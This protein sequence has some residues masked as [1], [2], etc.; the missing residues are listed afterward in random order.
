MAYNSCEHESIGCSPYKILHGENIVLPVDIL[1]D[2][3]YASDTYE[4]QEHV[5]GFVPKLQS[6]LKRIHAY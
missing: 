4:N 1:T 5:N 2:K 6:N 3:A